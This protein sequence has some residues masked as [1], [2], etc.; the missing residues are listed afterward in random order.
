MPQSLKN[1]FSKEY[2]WSVYCAVNDY[3]HILRYLEE[4]PTEQQIES[5][6]FFV[7]I[8]C[9]LAVVADKIL[10][11]FPYTYVLSEEQA[12]SY[13]ILLDGLRL[14]FL[15]YVEAYF[16]LLEN[17]SKIIDTVSTKGTKDKRRSWRNLD[18]D[19]LILDFLSKLIRHAEEIQ[20]T[21]NPQF[22]NPTTI[23]V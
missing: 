11:Y 21:L 7:D 13:K 19:K 2:I 9:L 1:I 6:K 22:F 5:S 4:R 15:T 3:I 14:D 8:K 10:E 17:F 20:N 18:K 16:D 12:K 23:K